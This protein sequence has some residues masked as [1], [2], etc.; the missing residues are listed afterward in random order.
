MG[1]KRW[2]FKAARK[3]VPFEWSEFNLVAPGQ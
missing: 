2:I 1:E 3:L